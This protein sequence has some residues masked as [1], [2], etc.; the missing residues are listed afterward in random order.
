MK[1]ILSAIAFCICSWAQAT[2]VVGG[3]PLADAV[4]ENTFSINVH[5]YEW[6]DTPEIPIG[7]RVSITCGHCVM[8]D[9][10]FHDKMKAGAD[11]TNSRYDKLKAGSY[12][13]PFLRGASYPYDVAVIIKSEDDA[14]TGPIVSVAKLRVQLQENLV[15]LGMGKNT[16]SPGALCDG[17]DPNHRYAYNTFRVVD[18]YE[19]NVGFIVNGTGLGSSAPNAATCFGDSG[20]YYFRT[21]PNQTV[22]L[23]GINSWGT[24]GGL[25]EERGNGEYKFAGYYSGAV[26]LTSPEIHQW[27][28]D[29]AK[30]N[31]VGICGINLECP[32]IKSPF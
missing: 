31:N 26:D 8:K 13:L 5:D 22:E 29:I 27:L 18:Y 7:P 25:T 17:M 14:I 2:T 6:I 10:I 30:K 24:E 16:S 3:K 9:Y 1:F 23:V 21:Q 19:Q 15:V 32:A 28:E 11:D 20:G 4:I 12:G